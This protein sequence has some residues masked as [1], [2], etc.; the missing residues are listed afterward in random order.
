TPLGRAAEVSEV[1]DMIDY[2]VSDKA[3]FV[4]GSTHVIDGGFTCR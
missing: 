2:L 1:V 3:A 4:T